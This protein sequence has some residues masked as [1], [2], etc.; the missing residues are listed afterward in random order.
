MKISLTQTEA[1]V[2]GVL[3]EKAVTTPDQYPLSLNAVTT[4][5]NQKSNR[6]P[7]TD[8]DQTETIAALDVLV[9]KHLIRERSDAGSRVAKYLH[10]LSGSLGLTYDFKE[11]ELAILCVLLLRGPQTV[12]EIRVRTGRLFAFAG[13]GE[14]EQVLERLG[15]HCDGPYVR[16]LDRE[17]GRK[18]ARYMHLLC[19][20][21]AGLAGA[22]IASEVHVSA[23]QARE[24][25]AAELNTG[26]RLA[27]LEHEVSQLRR[28]LADLKEQLGA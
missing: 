2:L 11:E 24:H 5:C 12:G 9:G 26:T 10:R 23:S 27:Q 17:P 4:G 8:I 3:L 15:V 25:S 14:V 19:E 18:E 28:E 21:G 22:A 13:L 7:V 1:R 16:C 20:D 6:D